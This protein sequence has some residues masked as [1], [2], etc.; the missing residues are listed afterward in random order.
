MTDQE[1]QELMQ[2]NARQNKFGSGLE[3]QEYQ[4]LEEAE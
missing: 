3:D 1:F 2:D 4:N